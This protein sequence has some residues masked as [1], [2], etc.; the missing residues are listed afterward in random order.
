M[1]GIAKIDTES[2]IGVIVEAMLPRFSDENLGLIVSLDMRLTDYGYGDDG[3]TRERPEKNVG[4]YL[5][6]MFIRPSN[7]TKVYFWESPKS[8]KG[9]DINPKYHR[10][11]VWD[12]I[13]DHDS[14]WRS[15]MGSA[16]C[17]A[18]FAMSKQF[19]GR[20][21]SGKELRPCD[22][23]EFTH[24]FYET[25]QY[26]RLV[27]NELVNPKVDRFSPEGRLTKIMYTDLTL[28]D[29]E[30]VR[31][32]TSNNAVVLKIKVDKNG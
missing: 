32:P 7:Y 2:V 15:S 23:S 24:L 25:P 8:S 11:L 1:S 5:H 17:D 31:K 9:L 22:L 14:C 20:K 28:A 19:N 3:N 26:V 10:E 27:K 12:M 13:C 6:F 21:K 29:I 30:G 16:I 4:K 18:Y